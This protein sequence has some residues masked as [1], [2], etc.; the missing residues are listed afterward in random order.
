MLREEEAYTNWRHNSLIYP[1]Y[2]LL[3]N[4]TKHVGSVKEQGCTAKRSGIKSTIVAGDTLCAC[5]NL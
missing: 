1:F 5:I 2:G 3:C 4:F